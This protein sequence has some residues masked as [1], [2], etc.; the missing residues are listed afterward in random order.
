VDAPP[1]AKQ[2]DPYDIRITLHCRRAL[3][4]DTEL[5]RY[6]VCVTVRQGVAILWGR[7][8]NDA[9]VQRAVL[10]VQRVPGVFQARANISVGPVEPDRDETPKLPGSIAI[11]ITSE[12]SSRVESPAKHGPRSR[13][14]L[15]GNARDPK[16]ARPEAAWMGRPES[17]RKPAGDPASAAVLLPPRP[18]EKREDVL[19]AVTRLIA[20]DVR[21]SGVHCEECNQVVTL[22]GSVAHAEHVM[23]LARQVAR[24]AGVKEVVVEYVRV[25]PP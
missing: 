21:Y 4:Q 12:Q 1:A 19:S 11:P 13:G 3:G 20:S 9:L 17:A 23:E 5:A 6:A 14:V 18:V 15:A 10:I 7:L 22:R 2:H 24:L 16:G 25:A 8:P